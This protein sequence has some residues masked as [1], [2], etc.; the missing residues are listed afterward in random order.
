MIVAIYTNPKNELKVPVK[1][2][3]SLVMATG[4]K[5]F[6][7]KDLNNQKSFVEISAQPHAYGAT[8]TMFRWVERNTLD[9]VRVIDDEFESI[10]DCDCSPDGSTTCANCSWIC[11][12]NPM[13]F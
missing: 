3:D 5:Y 4:N 10:D 2:A 7:I 12:A 6:L 8:R 13:V 9:N 11:T 1:V